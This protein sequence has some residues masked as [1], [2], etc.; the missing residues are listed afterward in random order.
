MWALAHF[1]IVLY[2]GTCRVRFTVTLFTGIMEIAKADPAVDR[3]ASAREGHRGIPVTY[4]TR[5]VN[6]AP[7]SVRP[8]APIGRPGV[9][10]RKTAA[11]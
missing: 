8:S 7:H 5:P 4:R 9:A 2:R 11:P 1:A 10:A 6:V 3:F